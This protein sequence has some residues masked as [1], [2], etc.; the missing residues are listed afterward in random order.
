M[1]RIGPNWAVCGDPAELRR[2]LSVRSPWVRA[3]WYRGL[4]LDPYR[5]STFSTLNE[6]V[7]DSLRAK[8][9]P[10]YSGKGLE[11]LGSLIN[12]QVARLVH[13]LDTKYVSADGELKVA[14]LASKVHYLTLDIVTVLA[15]GESFG[16]LDADAD[17]LGYMEATGRSGPWVAALGISPMAVEILQSPYLRWLIPDM[18]NLV[19]IGPVL[20]TVLKIVQERYGDSAVVGHDMLGSFV[21]HGLSREDAEGEMVAQIVAG[22]E[23]TATAIRATMLFIMTSPHVYRRLQDEIDRGVAEGRISSPI[24]DTQ[25]RSF[26]YLQ[27]IIREGLRVWPPATALQPKI[28]LKDEIVCG[29]RIPTGTNLA[30]SPWTF[31]RNT[32]VFGDD[33]HI[34]RPERWL[35][36]PVE[37]WRLMDQTVMMDFV[38]G[39]RYECLG[40]GIAMMELNRTF[41]EVPSLHH[42]HP[43]PA[44]DFR[45]DSLLTRDSLQLFRRFDFTLLDPTKPWTSF[46]TAFFVQKDMNVRI[47]RRPNPS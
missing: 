25:A 37:K 29:V 23:T 12:E 4:R 19:G 1:V 40:R 3:P 32:D 31:M 42:H 14:D 9:L 21:A 46:N 38:A 8:L 45:R 35:G 15:F 2:I 44:R 33:A 13:L 22:S 7:H 5:D 16:H 43:L 18:R 27:A 24:S 6:R 47:T 17:R 28:S 20:R 36:I 41:V 34:F 10:G 30:W 11:N 26:E 39:S